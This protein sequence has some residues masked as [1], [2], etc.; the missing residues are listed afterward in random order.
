MLVIARIAARQIERAPVDVD[1]VAALVQRL[2]VALAEARERVALAIQRL[3]RHVA[4]VVAAHGAV[5][6]Q[7]DR[8]VVA[9]AVQH[10]QLII[11][12]GAGRAHQLNILK[13]C[14]APEAER[15]A[16]AAVFKY[17]ARYQRLK[18]H[19]LLRQ[20]ALRR[21]EARIGRAHEAQVLAIDMHNAVYG[22]FHAEPQAGVV[23]VKLIR[24]APYTYI[25][26]D[27]N[28][29]IRRIPHH[30]APFAHT[31]DIIAHCG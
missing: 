27:S 6:V 19:R 31:A 9:A 22:L 2:L 29:R 7:F 30:Y 18:V 24:A 11:D 15:Q 12:K 20:S 4:H 13:Y 1:A 3:A 26:V 21:A 25:R 28:K 8:Y 5:H 14:R 16:H 10:L 17:I 23:V